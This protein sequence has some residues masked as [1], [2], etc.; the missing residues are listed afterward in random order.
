MPTPWIPLKATW[1]LST[2]YY[3]EE[4]DDFD[5]DF[6]KCNLE[7]KIGT[8]KYDTYYL[9]FN[10]DKDYD[11]DYA[12]CFHANC[13][14]QYRCHGGK[15]HYF[16]FDQPGVS[17]VYGPRYIILIVQGDRCT[18]IDKVKDAIECFLVN[19]RTSSGSDTL[20]SE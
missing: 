8:D 5:T 3:D 15:D 1:W 14:D 6:F 2:V 13:F 16:G 11:A 7:Y 19:S 9:R 10:L 4:D 17:V 18:Q 12:N 20:L